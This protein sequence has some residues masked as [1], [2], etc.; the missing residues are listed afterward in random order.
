[1]IP[2]RRDEYLRVHQALADAVDA[3]GFSTGAC[4][5]VLCAVTYAGMQSGGGGTP[6][7]ARELCRALREYARLS[8]GGLP[9]GAGRLISMNIY[10]SEDVGRIVYALVSTGLTRESPGNSPEDFA[11][12][13]TRE[14]FQTVRLP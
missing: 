13:F 1:V 5:L 8:C 12:L 10:G 11:G 7:C 9:A 14:N 2:G 3:S 6:V 4:W